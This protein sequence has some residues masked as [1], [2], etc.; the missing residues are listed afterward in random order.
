MMTVLERTPCKKPGPA[1]LFAACGGGE[2]SFLRQFPSW[3]SV[4]KD[5]SAPLAVHPQQNSHETCIS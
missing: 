1:G 2:T 3:V 5:A 4:R